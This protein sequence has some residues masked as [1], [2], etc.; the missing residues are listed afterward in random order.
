M[1][2]WHHTVRTLFNLM[3]HKESPKNSNW[4]IVIMTD[5]PWTTNTSP[6]KYTPLHKKEFKIALKLIIALKNNIT[7]LVVDVTVICWVSY[8][9]I[10]KNDMSFVTALNKDDPWR[11]ECFELH[12]I[13]VAELLFVKW[14]HVT[15]KWQNLKSFCLTKYTLMVEW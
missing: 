1:I 15:R 7:C 11:W 6:S 3:A 12:H 8:C 5:K 2:I 10:C 9:I 4:Q 14:K 13:Y